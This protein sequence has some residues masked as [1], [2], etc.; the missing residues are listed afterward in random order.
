MRRLLSILTLTV[1][2]L[3]C[4][5]KPAQQP[6]SDDWTREGVVYELNVRQLTPEGTFAAAEAH[7][8]LLK[9][10]GVEIVW[11]MPP[12]PIG[13]KGRKGTLGSYYAIRDYCDINPEFGTLADFDHFL[14][15][16]HEQGFKVVLD[17][18]ANHTS[19]DH[20]WVTEKPAEWYVRDADGN[21]I[22]EY[23]WTDIAK[24]NYDCA[25]MRA[26]MEKCMRFWLDRGIDGFRC[27][28]A[29]QV[30]Q[31]FWASVL[32]KFREEY[33]RPLYF[34][35]EGEESWLHE[36]GFTTTYAW[37]LHH[38]LNDLAQGK[39][40]ADSLVRY[41]QWNQDNY[42]SGCRR[43]GFTSNHD[44]NSW[45]GTEFE[46]MGE[47]WYAMTVLAW[48]LPQMQPL[49]YTG[50]EVGCN[51]RFAFFEKDAIPAIKTNEFTDIYRYLAT[52]RREHPAMIP[53]HGSF[54]L[55]SWDND[56]M[57]YER[58]AEDDWVKVSVQLKA[59]WSVSIETD[60]ARVERIEPY[61]W[62]VGM[63]TPLQLL[64][65][66]EG[67]GAYDVQ[68]EGGKG[69]SV[70]ETH[71]AESPNYLFVDV[72]IGPK[73]RPG[74]YRLVFTKGGDRFSIPYELAAREE[75]SAERRSFGAEDA[76]YLI[77]PDRFVNGDP[78]NDNTVYT[79]E[80]ADYKAFFGRHGGDLQGIEDQLD[81]IAD[82]GFTAIWC[83]PLLEDDEPDASYHGYACTDYYRIDP[84]FGSNWKY[85][86]YVRL[87]HEKGL[88]VIM[89]VVTNHCGDK[90]WWMEDL[91][92]ADW[93]NAWPSYTHSNCAFSAQNDPYCSELDRANMEGGWFDVSMADM[94]LDN[95]YVLRYF[96]QWAVWWTEWAGLDGFRVDTYPYN[97]KVPMSQWC[98]AVRKEYPRLNIV[99]EVW[100]TNVPQVA[101]WQAGNPN[102][103]GFDS[104]LPSV[105]DFA[106]QSAIC[107]GINTDHENWDEGITKWYDSIANDVYIHAPYNMMV[108][109]GNHDTDRI[110][111]V[112][113][114]DPAKMK[115]IMALLSTVRG[116][117]QWFAGDELMVVSRDRAQGHGGLRV[118]FPL[119]WEQNPV[120]KELHDY[121][122]ALLQFRKTSREIQQGNTL[123][124]LTRDNTYA[125]F[126]YIET[127]KGTEA[128]FV[129]L[130]NNPEPRQIP[131]DDYKEIT[132]KLDTFDGYDVVT[133]ESVNFEEPLTVAGRSALV[134]HLPYNEQRMIV[135]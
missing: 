95:P 15:T 65:K 90:H 119:G 132:R 25:E 99:G 16:A 51:H 118:E 39:A 57:V 91:P 75:H 54:K 85:R 104:N 62:W 122:R 59:P 76:V 81:Y 100:S 53:G 9:E 114:Q 12:Y 34:L 130:N 86:E 69:V 102:L 109:P 20:P 31:D 106:L 94:N 40:D 98:A 68:I 88:K 84:R 117:P 32:P 45:S 82:L 101:Y 24:L 112:V 48:T 61:C 7:L 41:L 126:R 115:L 2:A 96:Q 13:E 113:G 133:G 36:A 6:V 43:L 38:L 71:T 129:Y 131:W 18:V 83:T 27:D 128:V 21:T 4:T 46:R 66:G 17:W 111:D 92:F 8:P 3:A 124:F 121:L 37:K 56:T 89:D 10:L 93:I 87:A 44:E 108:F 30:P 74:L 67:V 123:H 33:K 47:A 125:Y 78:S 55:L 105:M 135:Y 70:T 116:Y 42:P 35:A 52:L 107:Q 19:P 23:D 60:E 77:M 58:R 1:L 127:T 134:I 80:T 14:A 103:D 97:E 28:V 73:A 72:A 50:Q 79:R 26:E 11:I 29:Y 63:E 110:G 22:V 49:L 5:Q 64:V 120:Q